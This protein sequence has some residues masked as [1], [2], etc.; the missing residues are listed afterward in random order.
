MY[1]EVFS[2]RLKEV[3]KSHGFT[4]REVA[5][6]LN[7]NFQ[8]ISRYETSITEPD[9]ETLAQ[10]SDFYG[11]SIDWLIGVRTLPGKRE[12]FLRPVSKWNG[13]K[14]RSTGFPRKMKLA[15]AALNISQA[16][17]AKG[18]EIP[19]STLTKYELGQLQPNI[20][21]LARTVLFYNITADWLLG[22]SELPSP[23][24]F[25]VS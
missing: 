16:K 4:L 22:L 25:E 21:V 6:E 20:E 14:I 7:I 15:R 18:I 12:D 11:A 17:A 10:L 13:I 19:R 2:S 1:S 9:I 8:N 23:L 5:A 24:L 3:R